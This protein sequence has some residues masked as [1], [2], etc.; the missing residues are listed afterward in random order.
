MDDIEKL[1]G[2]LINITDCN[3]FEGLGDCR[4]TGGLCVDNEN[5]V[6]KQ[7]E[8]LKQDIEAYKQSEQEAEEIIAE[9]K[10]KNEELK[11]QIKYDSRINDM[12]AEID[13]GDRLIN[14]Y[15]NAF[16]EIKSYLNT[17]N[18]I[19]GDFVNTETYLRIISVINEVANETK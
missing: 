16:E 13:C 14:K 18:S 8:K 17:L 2:Y 4:K 1:N 7:I 5:C 3:Y 15:K 9:L 10:Y 19:D 11:K 12:Q 6:Y